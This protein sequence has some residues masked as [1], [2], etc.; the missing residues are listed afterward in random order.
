[1]GGNRWQ[2]GGGIVNLRQT[3]EVAAL[4][5]MV[6]EHVV[7][8]EEPIATN[9]LHAYWKSSQLRLKCWFAGLRTSPPGR[10]T[11]LPPFHLR[12][13]VCLS[14]EILVAELLT[15]VWSTV[16]LARDVYHANDECQQLARHVFLGQ[17]EARHE[18][19]KMLADPNRLP[20]RE[21]T[22]IDRLRRRVERWTDVLVGPMVIQYGVTD[23]AFDVERA[24]DHGPTQSPLSFSGPNAAASQLTL[25][26]LTHAIPRTTHIDHARAVLDLAVA[27]AVL[28][29]IPPQALTLHRGTELSSLPPESDALPLPPSPSISGFRIADS[30]RKSG[31]TDRPASE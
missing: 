18:V 5:S 3:A 14:R 11:T 22:A 9:A 24:K 31:G 4:A 17:M 15:R 26:G 12:Q 1:M 16:L 20:S 29:A 27:R 10:T 25:V 19:L 6:S 2:S 7:Q 30:R 21:T 8:A 23:F 28:T 13:Q